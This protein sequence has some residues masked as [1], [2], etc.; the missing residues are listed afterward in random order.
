M[1]A[2]DQPP[3]AISPPKPRRPDR[4]GQVLRAFGVL[5][6]FGALG[7]ASY[8]AWV[9]WGTGFLTARSQHALRQQIEQRIRHRSAVPVQSSVPG[10]AVAILDIPKI[11][12]GMVVVEG[13]STD[14]LEKGPGH[15]LH[16]AY[17]WQQKGRVGIAGHRTTY[18][19][20]FWNLDK[21]V[22]GDRVT[23]VTEYGTFEYSVTGSRVVLPR[24]VWV[25]HQ[26]KDP[27][28]VLTACTPRFSASHRLVVFAKRVAG[29]GTGPSIH[30]A[31]PP[32]DEVGP[33]DGVVRPLVFTLA[34]SFL[35]GMVYLAAVALARRRG[36]LR[37]GAGQI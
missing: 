8:I 3:R 19:H 30:V 33:G 6:L 14:D 34:A 27:T 21:L 32:A 36:T 29:A 2:T 25:L 16:T 10:K 20:P 4:I 18:L 37:A 28:L 11:H 1:T 17:P 35:A 23:L 26:T 5:C 7:T 31:A 13:T 9:E 24:A 12:L 22:P 15:Y